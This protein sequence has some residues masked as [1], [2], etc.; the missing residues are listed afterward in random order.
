MFAPRAELKKLI[1]GILTDSR[2]PGEPK[3]TEGSALFQLYQA[4][5]SKDDTAA[6]AQAFA[7]GIAWGD[8]K[9]VLFEKIDAEIS[10]LRER[11]EALMA[12]PG[13]IEIILRDGAARL[14]TAYALSLIHI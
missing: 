8:A 11:Y 4:F 12:K 2:A 13:E 14:R 10:P 1:A 6:F 5:A 3:S 7:D 9:H